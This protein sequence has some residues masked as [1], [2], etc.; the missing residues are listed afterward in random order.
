MNKEK[1]KLI[2]A[3][4]FSEFENDEEWIDST[5]E[6]ISLISSGGTP[7]RA[8]PEYW[9][10]DIPWISTTLINYNKIIAAKEFITEL[11]LN[12][13]ST[14][15]FPKGTILMAMY[16]QGKTRGK[17]AVLDINASINQACAAIS[18]KEGM[19][20]EFVFQN[21][22]S[23]YEE[24]RKIS[25][26][27]GQK[28]LSSSLIKKISF[29]YPRIESEE[30]QKIANCLSSLDNVITAETEKL[31]H[32]KDHKKGLLQQLFPAIGETKPQFRF[33]EFLNDGDWEEKELGEVAKFRRGSFPQPYG[34]PKWYDDKNGHPFIQVYDVAKNLR[35]KSKT[36]RKISGLA[37][38]QSVFIEK[39]TIIITIQGSIG[40]VAITQYDAYIDRTLLLFEEFFRPFD[41]LFFA[42]VL[43]TLFEIEKQNAPG[44][45][46]KTIT[47]QVLTQFK[48]FIPK[49]NEQE[50]IGGCLFSLDSLI[51]AQTTKIEAL[52]AHKK[53]LMQQLFPKNI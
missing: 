45:I 8:K 13:S 43:Q 44:G 48:V 23:R 9:N 20:I 11:G 16:G 3:L 28:N 52:K 10:G 37:A 19:S 6:E 41:K 14:K 2:P 53:G 4:R 38:G 1:Q 27:G 29:I 40:R 22:S 7:S 30:Q 33:P 21:L 24:I 17:V 15:M 32:L 31:D 18:L 36:K 5:I 47:K 34:L 46:I 25:N 49:I 42:Y 50:K 26:E 39:G 35:L 51:E 12:N